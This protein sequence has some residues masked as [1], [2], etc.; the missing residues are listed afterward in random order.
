MIV[1]KV[2]NLSGNF[3]YSVIVIF[4]GYYDE[5]KVWLYFGKYDC[6]DDKYIY[7]V[8]MNGYIQYD[9]VEGIIWMNGLEIIDGIGQFYF[10]GLLISNFVVC[11]WYY[12]GCVDGLDV[13]GS[14]SGMMVSVMY[15]V[16]KGVYFFI[17]YIYVKYCFDYVD[18]EII[19]FMQFGI[20]Y[21]YGGGCFVMVF[22]SCFYMKNV[23]YDFSD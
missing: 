9:F 6:Y 20:W 18:D 8:M 1:L 16:L 17:V 5:S 10:M 21:E 12:I 13:L 14:E 2:Q 19:F 3:C 15:E 7:L 22:D 23:F 4:V 11:V